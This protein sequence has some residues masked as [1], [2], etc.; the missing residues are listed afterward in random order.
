MRRFQLLFA[1]LISI[2]LLATSSIEP[3]LAQGKVITDKMFSTSLEG[4]L[5]NDPSTREMNIYLPPSYDEGDT[6]Y[7]VIY[8]LHGYTV[9]HAAWVAKDTSSM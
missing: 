1:M 9:N 3:A 5:L 8:Y 4:N 6:R 2:A 7:P